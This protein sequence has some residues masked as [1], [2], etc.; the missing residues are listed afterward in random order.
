MDGPIELVLPSIS[1]TPWAA[2]AARPHEVSRDQLTEAETMARELGPQLATCLTTERAC[3]DEVRQLSQTRGGLD[4]LL[5]KLQEQFQKLWL[6]S[7]D[8]L[9]DTLDACDSLAL[10]ERLQPHDYHIRF[11]TDAKGR[12]EVRIRAARLRRLEATLER[13]KLEALE[14]QLLAVI[15]HGR[16]VAA[17][18]AVFSE[19]GE[20]S[21]IGKRTETLRAIARSKMEQVAIAETELRAERNRQL[22]AEQVALA[23]GTI[24]RAQVASTIPSLGGSTT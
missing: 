13:C 1:A 3:V 5:T 8:E 9:I 19:E 14:A 7:L 6:P 11:V 10:S 18:S 2:F 15:S 22:A 16:T 24:T 4:A 23:Q 21:V 20:V 17:L 12:V